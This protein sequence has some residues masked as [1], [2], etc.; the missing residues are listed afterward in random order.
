MGFDTPLWLWA[1]LAGA[2]PLV[3]HRI[4]RK[5]LKV[6]QLPT[7]ALLAD[8]HARQRRRSGLNDRLLLW[9]RIA[10]LLCLALALS[11]PYMR[12]EVAFGD[13]DVSSV[14]IV[15]DDSMSMR[16]QQG[17][18]SLLDQ[19]I[20][21]AQAVLRGLPAG[22]EAG[23]V[24]AGQPARTLL[25]IT[26]DLDG[27][28]RALRSVVAADRGTDLNGGLAL[29][30]QK[31]EGAFHKKRQLLVLSDF[32]R[33]AK[34]D[35]GLVERSSVEVHLESLAV[36]GPTKNL[37]IR[38]AR[39]VP[40]GPGT[41]A[42]SVL[43]TAQGP[44]P[45]DP[46]LEVTLP[47]AAQQRHALRFDEEGQARVSLRLPTPKPG[48]DPAVE[49]RIGPPDSLAADNRTQ[50]L[51]GQASGVRILL[52]NGDPHPGSRDDELYYAARALSL[53]PSTLATFRVRTIDG[54]SLAHEDLSQNDVVV[55]ANVAAPPVTTVAKLQAFVEAGGG[56]LITAGDHLESQ[57]YNTRLE[58][59]LPG[60]ISA[61]GQSQP[62]GLAPPVQDWADLHHLD[63]TQTRK[64][65]L[66][67]SRDKELL[68][69]NDGAPAVLS[70]QVG[71][72]QVLLLTTTLD[73]GWT[74]LPIRPSYLPI[75]TNLVRVA[76]GSRATF[77][78]N[79]RAGEA[80]QLPVPAGATVLE[81]LDP[82]GVRTRFD[83]STEQ[84]VVFQR[85]YQSG[86]YRILAGVQDGPLHFVPQRAFMVER[87]QQD[88]DLQ[89]G[90]Y[91]SGVLRSGQSHG[92]AATIRRPLAPYL[93]IL[94]ALLAIAETFL[95][96]SGWSTL[97]RWRSQ[98]A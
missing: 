51:L 33:H 27:A 37:A 93:W 34:L 17:G 55:L 32:A 59:L 30:L 48:Q 5:D 67:D 57:A 31:L 68:R 35:A 41:V 12:T 44:V 60:H 65:L 25:D 10:L 8:V 6:V 80:V 20:A 76:A 28:Q 73:D 22:A 98:P 74:D 70:R 69:Y 56:V 49:L 71:E 7:F 91:Q 92:Q 87:P 81:V 96:C 86:A 42:M 63:K 19:A 23:V 18:H 15:V 21:R 82:D 29:G 52:V 24:L 89:A 66:V 77:E 95:R 61:P 46:Y 50:R 13:G 72:G 9:T 85:T 97:K 39:A 83:A 36:E 94:A 38:E 1:L 16:Q 58:A 90:D 2:L 88:S 62:V 43:V 40:S 54:A 75:L 47:L 45:N 78:T 11:A 79:Y 14:V 64:R 84:P 3:A 26:D 53:V 4:R